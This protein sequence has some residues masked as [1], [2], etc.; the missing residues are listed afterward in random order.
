MISK[1]CLTAVVMATIFNLSQAQTAQNLNV[2]QMSGST[3]AN[4]SQSSGRDSFTP[5]YPLQPASTSVATTPK[6]VTTNGTMVVIDKFVPVSNERPRPKPA[7]LKDEPDISMQGKSS[8]GSVPSQAVLNLPL[9]ET[10]TLNP[11]KLPR[12]QEMPGLGVMPGS[13]A[14]YQIKSVRVGSDRNEL[15]YISLQQLNKISTP[16]ESP[17]V[18][19][20]TGATL[21]A[22]GQDIF[23]KS[24]NNEPFTLYISDNGNGQAIGLTLVPQPNLPAQSIVLVPDRPT[25]SGAA[26]STNAPEMIAPDY[27]GRLI[28]LTKKLALGGVPQGFTKSRL[29]RS[30]ANDGKAIFEPLHKYSGSVYDIYSYSVKSV[31]K[32]PV[33]LNEES[34]YTDS[35]RAVAF[36]PHTVLQADEL[37]TV[38]IIVDRNVSGASK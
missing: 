4:P 25:V 7:R 20:A 16:F 30:L 24:A 32:E 36:Y 22:I 2:L 3:D 23:V 9:A 38:Y 18:V 26:A 1:K 12:T 19:D 37:T 28:G 13:Q 34:F 6:V 11:V 33:E 5:R 31:L 15:V 17:Q 35:V 21:K 29:P 14:D 8:V 27:T 10:T